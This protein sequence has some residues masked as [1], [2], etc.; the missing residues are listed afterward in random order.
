MAR[1]PGKLPTRDDL[2]PLPPARSGIRSAAH[3]DASSIGTAAAGLGREISR[4]G[5]AVQE[6]VDQDEA[7]DVERR[8]IE[9]REEQERRLLDESSSMA[10]GGE[11]FA[12]NFRNTYDQSAVGALGRAEQE[13]L[14]PRGMARFGRGLYENAARAETRALSREIEERSRR[15]E[16]QTV[17]TLGRLQNRAIA[18]PSPSNIASLIDEGE[19]LIGASRLPNP[20]RAGVRQNF[21]S[22]MT[23]ASVNQR[24]DNGDVEGT[25]RDL[26]QLQGRAGQDGRGYDPYGSSPD[27]QERGSSAA[28]HA[29]DL[30]SVSAR[31]ESGGRG[32]GFISSGRGDP[33]GQSYG[34]HQLSGAYSMG[35]FLASPEGEPYRG[36]F[37]NARP[38]TAAF[39]QIYRNTAALDPQAFADAQ[40]AFY[41]RTHYEPLRA[42]AEQN[43][44]DVSNRGVQEALFSMSVQHEGAA[45]IVT[46]AAQSL[47][48]GSSAEDQIRALYQARTQYVQRLNTLPEETRNSVLGR[49]ERE[50]NDALALAG[51]G[52]ASHGFTFSDNPSPYPHLSPAERGTLIR[53]LQ[54]RL[55]ESTAHQLR[56]SIA[57]ILDGQEPE[58][59]SQGRTALDRA[60]LIMTPNQHTRWANRW[61]EAV[62]RRQATGDLNHLTNEDITRRINGLPPGLRSSVSRLADRILDVRENDPSRAAEGGNLQGAD[63][64]T[65]YTA[66]P[67]G[68]PVALGD[69]DAD[70][71][72]QRAPELTRVYERLR[73]RHPDL[74]IGTDENG[75]LVMQMR[76]QPDI[77]SRRTADGAASF[78]ADPAQQA[79]AQRAAQ[80]QAWA[81]I[82]DARLA[83]QAR[84]GIPE[85]RRSPITRAEAQQLLSLPRNI[86]PNEVT[87]RV[88]QAADR[89][90][91]IYGPR[92][93]E[94]MNHVLRFQTTLSGDR[95]DQARGDMLSRLTR[96][97]R[98][99]DSDVNTFLSLQR[100]DAEQR[101]W[102]GETPSDWGRS[103]RPPGRFSWR[104]AEHGA[105]ND[106]FSYLSPVGPQGLS[107]GGQG[108]DGAQPAARASEPE[109]PDPEDIAWLRENLAERSGAFDQVFGDG[110]AARHG[111]QEEQ[112][113]P[114]ARRRPPR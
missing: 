92:A 101:G 10:P 33:G 99:S 107:I 71:R 106:M 52:T 103:G 57:G 79:A 64:R 4:I 42:T 13:G 114:R 84:V 12:S 77:V 59:D 40:R 113:Q 55:R 56:E 45:R 100:L 16:E 5:T 108:R 19:R 102:M 24:A 70:Y 28:E 21:I 88:Q 58:R 34:V 18:D 36:A 83:Y 26:Q 66:G 85:E 23:R 109:Q 98:L 60:A 67:N 105:A 65:R 31:Y 81:A 62:A 48:P 8:L 78:Q 32:V 2:G 3:A 82:M 96:G 49:F 76:P 41:T 29:P 91:A 44:F 110:A 69:E 104:A 111:Q 50:V 7:F 38:G 6:R 39:N 25:I 94:V 90:Q 37:G 46:R 89:I 72:M 22:D 51:A 61:N 73:R 112:E 15:H 75:A 43:G 80:Q 20:R 30:G 14:S 11:G 97:D 74:M 35:A 87:R 9:F 86:D 68:E 95:L 54:V 63:R 47:Q 27:I 93:R 1:L 17:E 53:N